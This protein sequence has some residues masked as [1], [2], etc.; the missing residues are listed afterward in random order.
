MTDKLV[1]E[2]PSVVTGSKAWEMGAEDWKKVL[3]GAGIA[4]GSSLLLLLANQ[5]ETISNQID[6]GVYEAISI[7]VVST[8]VNAIRKF[9]SDTRG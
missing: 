9:V 7:A 8:L 6:F 2:S 3:R 1:K 5:I 4:F